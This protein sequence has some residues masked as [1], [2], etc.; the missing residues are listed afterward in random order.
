MKRFFSF[1]ILFFVLSCIGNIYAQTDS[2][3]KYPPNV[4]ITE[5]VLNFGKTFKN[6]PSMPKIGMA[7]V[8]EMSFEWQ[9]TGRKDW[10]H[11]Y[12]FP[13]LGFSFLYGIFGNDLIIGRNYAVMPHMG[14]DFFKMIEM[15][16]GCGFAY[17]PIIHNV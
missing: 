12:N 3:V 8:N 1:G 7:Y 15:R 5:P 2:V 16:I 10:H 4:F 9:T 13:R 14:F 6:T 17:F 11:H